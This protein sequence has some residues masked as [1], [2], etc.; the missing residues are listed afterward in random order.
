MGK[1]QNKPKTL[2]DQIRAA[3][4]DCGETRYRVAKNTGLSEP[5]LCRFASGQGLSLPGLDTLA[6][7]LGLEIVIRE[8]PTVD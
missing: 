2:T 8:K 5:Q 3:L 1:K 6:E 4:A 7:Y